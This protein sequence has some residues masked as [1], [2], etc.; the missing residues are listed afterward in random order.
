[1]MVKMKQQ[2]HKAQRALGKTRGLAARLSSNRRDG[3]PIYTHSDIALI[4]KRETAFH[5]LESFALR[6]I[7]G[8]DLNRPE[9]GCN[10]PNA[11]KCRQ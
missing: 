1:M 7:P 6:L 9:H 5:I 2:L 4:T 11:V 3:G 10:S 8:I